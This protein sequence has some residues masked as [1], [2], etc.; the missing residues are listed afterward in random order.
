VRLKG[1]NTDFNKVFNQAVTSITLSTH[2]LTNVDWDLDNNGKLSAEGSGALSNYNDE[3]KAINRAMK[4]DDAYDRN[5]YHLYLVPH[6]DDAGLLGYMPLKRQA[7]FIITQASGNQTEQGIQRTIAHE[8]SHGIFRLR[9]T[10]SPH[11]KYIANQST[12]QN[13]MDYVQPSSS[14]TANNL[15]KYQWDFIHDPEKM[16][17]LFED[18]EE[19]QLVVESDLAEATRLIRSI[20]CAKDGG[21]STFDIYISGQLNITAGALCRSLGMTCPSGLEN[22]KLLFN[23][24]SAGSQSNSSYS[25]LTLDVTSINEVSGQMVIKGSP[26]DYHFMVSPVEYE[27]VNKIFSFIKSIF[28]QGNITQ[29]VVNANET[30]L[31][32]LKC[33]SPCSI[34]ELS[35][36]ARIAF[37]EQIN[38]EFA[39]WETWE[40]LINDLISLF[41]TEEQKSTFYQSIKDNH[42]LIIDLYSGFSAENKEIFVRQFSKLAIENTAEISVQPNHYYLWDNEP[43][44]KVV[45]KKNTSDF[46]MYMAYY[47]FKGA[48]PKTWSEYQFK[49]FEFLGVCYSNDEVSNEDEIIIVPSIYLYWLYETK[50][51][52]QSIQAISYFANFIGVS[53]AGRIL[54]KGGAKI[55]QTIAIA[56]L[57]SFTLDYILQINDVR[58]KIKEIDGGKEFLDSW[59]IVKIA[60]DLTTVSTDVITSF[61]ANG[62]KVLAGNHGLSD[63]ASDVIQKHI[64]KLIT[65]ANKAKLH[66][67]VKGALRDVP[68]IK[69]IEGLLKE[70]E[71][72]YIF[73][74]DKNGMCKAMAQGDETTVQLPKGNY[75][76]CI[77][78]HNH[79]GSDWHGLSSIP[80]WK[81]QSFSMWDI[82]KTGVIEFSELR[83]VCKKSQNTFVL[84]KS[85]NSPLSF[86][87]VLDDEISV[88][89][90]LDDLWFENS[91]IRNMAEYRYSNY[92]S[93]GER[94]EWERLVKEG[95]SDKYLKWSLVSNEMFENIR[96]RLQ[97][98]LNIDYLIE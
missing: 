41:N 2:E 23:A 97:S 33:L 34:K 67:I 61:T 85:D 13:L 37:L 14:N 5:T 91:E 96:I 18:D 1:K 45:G 12:T 51:L 7:G 24:G 17:G 15:R 82:Q 90:F 21:E 81:G 8:L 47:Q 58:D 72:E 31:E 20:Y 88:V 29:P 94:T 80:G 26:S 16:I 19:G 53:S 62:R 74:Y 50:E 27:D 11:N 6:F 98:E 68:D 59:E 46:T 86:E 4:K 3:M 66:K 89:E 52:E 55:A 60:V 75:T 78:T 83:A 56:E 22:K 95:A 87:E 76:G 70:A 79:P 57:S 43:I 93:E 42:S 73:V 32:E 25:K 64:D 39:I 49:P 71:I 40:V 92:L 30:T 63:D 36:G 10:F 69:T 38:K 77:A 44:V 84:R 28:T 54:I 35:A 65:G 9:H 48:I